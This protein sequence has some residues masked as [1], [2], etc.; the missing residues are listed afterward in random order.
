MLGSPLAEV[1][2]IGDAMRHEGA[3]IVPTLL[4]YTAPRKHRDGAYERVLNA[5]GALH[6]IGDEA[7]HSDVRLIDGSDEPLRTL[8]AAIQCELFGVAWDEAWRRSSHAARAR[9]V[10]DAYLADR[11]PH[12]QPLRALE[13]VTFRFEV[14][15][16]Y[17]AWRDLQRHRMVS[18]TTPRLGTSAGWWLSPELAEL[19]FEDVCRDALEAAVDT[20]ARLAAS[21][22][23]EAQY[24]VP[25]AFRVRY[26]MHANLREMF[27][28][29]ELRSAR[30]GHESY[31]RVAQGLAECLL[32]ACPWLATHLRVDR[33]QYPWARH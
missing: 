19:G 6:A 13:Q 4:K 22:P 3:A 21:H 5:R 20:H 25:L 9:Q 17:G 10:V 29:I 27:H 24:A 11:G 7:P 16:D 23:W 32:S 28:L 12:D 1:R 31:R 15:C 2:R 14:C 8:A 30:Q 26:V 18:A 33:N